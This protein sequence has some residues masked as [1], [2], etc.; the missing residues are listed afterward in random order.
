MPNV[1][2]ADGTVI[3]FDQAGSGPAVVLIGAGPTDRNANADVAALLAETCTVINYDRR[4]RGRSGDTP[5]YSV[6]RE[7]EDLSA[8][9]ATVDG[10]VQLF[11]TSGGAFLGFRAVAAGLRCAGIAVWEPPYVLPGSRP[12]VPGDYQRRMT[13]LAEA[14]D[15]GGMVELF[16]TVAVGMPP[17]FVVG[18]RQGPYWEFVEA[19][20][21]PALMYDAE[22]AG[23]FSLPTTQ[24]AAVGCPVL[25]IDGGTT[26]WLTQAS[27]AVAAALPKGSRQ[28]L[29]G[30]Q[31]NVEASALVPTLSAFFTRS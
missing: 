26:P 5:P 29:T 18:M 9:T 13:E 22:L 3:D 15:H 12:P 19:A 30:Q 28:T 20:A 2:S 6:D 4:G 8:I 23:D 31:H 7:L 14:K 16:M 11:C 21:S 10:D 1:H 25:I 17:E 24:L 27:D